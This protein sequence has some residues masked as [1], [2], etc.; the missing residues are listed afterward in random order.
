MTAQEFE[1]AIVYYLT[2]L[3]GLSG[4]HPKRLR[5]L[6]ESSGIKM[7]QQGRRVVV[8]RVDLRDSMPQIY[9]G[10]LQR[11]RGQPGKRG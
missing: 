10:L 6:L 8:S 9:E 2:D 3:A 7:L 5:R 4:M 1:L 11:L